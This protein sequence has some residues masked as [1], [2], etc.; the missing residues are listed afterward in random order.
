MISSTVA[1]P[2]A[3]VDRAIKLKDPGEFTAAYGQLTASYNACHRS[4]RSGSNCDSATDGLLVSGSGFSR[5][6]Q[7]IGS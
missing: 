3:A 7:M 5:A 6:R 4:L 1:Q 2:L